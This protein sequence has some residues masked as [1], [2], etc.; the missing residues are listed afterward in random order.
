MAF[1][2]R[3]DI[4][5]YKGD[6]FEFRIYPKDSSGNA[7]QFDSY[8][9]FRFTISDQL[10]DNETR[11]EINGFA[12][13]EN[14]QY[15][16]CAI[17][18]ENGL[19]MNAGQTYYY[20]VEIGKLG[21]DYDFIYTLLQGNI[22][23]SEQVTLPTSVPNAPQNVSLIFSS[24]S[25]G[26][27]SWSAPTGTSPVGG[28]NV[29]L[30]VGPLEFKINEEPISSSLTTVPFVLTEAQQLQFPPGSTVT[31]GVRAENTTG[32]GAIATAQATIPSGA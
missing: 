32:V 27:L 16:L 26:I 1:P 5:Y 28:Y 20:D 3:Y 2:G 8:T 4:N 12:K 7:F 11:T 31:V 13:N 18:P 6:T 14:N 22:S 21:N 15:I 29:Y 30:V 23:V 17:T 10:G 25:T 9:Q 24:S 19:A